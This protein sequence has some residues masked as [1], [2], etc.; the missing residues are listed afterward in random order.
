MKLPVSFQG[1]L[2]P[3]TQ[4]I[5]PFFLISQK[6]LISTFT[7]P[8]KYTTYGGCCN[9]KWAFLDL[10]TRKTPPSTT[11]HKTSEGSRSL[12][13]LRYLHTCR[14]SRFR[15]GGKK[16]ESHYLSVEFPDFFFTSL[17]IFLYQGLAGLFLSFT[18]AWCWVKS[19]GELSLAGNIPVF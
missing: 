7:L 1:I 11:R 10:S 17:Q 12:F 13:V 9:K 16:I 3:F 2:F 6:F 5:T 4:F 14:L 19:S 8:A 18:L 15:R